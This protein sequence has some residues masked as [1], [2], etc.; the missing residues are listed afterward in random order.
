MSSP[1]ILLSAR[2]KLEKGEPGKGLDPFPLSELP[3]DRN[4]NV[5][6]AIRS[7]YGLSLV[8]ISALKNF[9]F[10][11]ATSGTTLGTTG[12]VPGAAAAAPG[13][14]SALDERIANL[15]GRLLHAEQQ[16]KFTSPISVVLSY[17]YR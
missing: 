16:G 12:D 10:S 1:S 9:M 8:E 14:S 5:W 15:E 2:M 11:A 4:D 6:E 7:E 13:T 17:S 3:T